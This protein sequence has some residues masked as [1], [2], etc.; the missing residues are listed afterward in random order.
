MSINMVDF[1]E[2]CRSVSIQIHLLE[3]LKPNHV[4]AVSLRLSRSYIFF[5]LTAMF[6]DEANFC[7]NVCKYKW[8]SLHSEKFTLWYDIHASGITGPYSFGRAQEVCFP[9]NFI[10]GQCWTIIVSQLLLKIIGGILVFSRMALYATFSCMIMWN[11]KC[12]LINSRATEFLNITI[13]NIIR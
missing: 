6:I 4:V 5:H 8:T 10:I 7:L 1:T 2:R 12:T 11:S 9:V 13:R 3:E